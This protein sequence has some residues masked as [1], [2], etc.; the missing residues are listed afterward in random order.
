MM[1]RGALL[2]TVRARLRLLRAGLGTV[3]QGPRGTDETI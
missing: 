2:D 3:T 1:E